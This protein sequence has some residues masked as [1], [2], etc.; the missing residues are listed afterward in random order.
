MPTLNIKDIPE[1]KIV[2]IVDLSE[3]SINEIAETV[4]RKIK[5]QERTSIVHGHNTVDAVEVVRCKDCKYFYDG[6]CSIHADK[7]LMDNDDFC[8]WGERKDD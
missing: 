7:V 5:E 3:D 1:S 4:V 2:K 6:V 8:S